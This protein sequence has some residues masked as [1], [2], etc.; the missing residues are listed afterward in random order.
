MKEKIETQEQWISKHHVSAITKANRIASL[1]PLQRD[2]TERDWRTV[3]QQGVWG[4]SGEP[5]DRD[6]RRCFPKAL[7]NGLKSA[8]LLHQ[9]GFL[10]VSDSARM[11]RCRE[12]FEHAFLCQAR[13]C[14]MLSLKIIEVVK[15]FFSDHINNM[16]RHMHRGTQGGN[17][18]E[19][20]YINRVFRASI[21]FRHR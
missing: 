3:W 16:I 17:N 14:R 7:V 21:E 2:A 12:T 19:C 13:I 9:A 20:F 4:N 8:S 11:K 18:A 6:E 1:S 5:Q 10:E 15:Q